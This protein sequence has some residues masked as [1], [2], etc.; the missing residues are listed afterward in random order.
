MPLILETKRLIMRPFQDSDL[1]SFAAYRAD[2][3]V[4]EYQGWSMP[5]T[6]KDAAQLITEMKQQQPAIPGQWYQLALEVKA[7]GVMI[8]DCAFYTLTNDPRQAE[9][10]FTLARPYQGQGYAYEAVA[11]LLDYLFGELKLHRVRAN[12]D[13]ENQH[14]SKLLERLG[15][16]REAHFVENLWFKGR[17]SSEYW[18]GML[19]REWDR[20]ELL[21]GG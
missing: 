12:C 10:G 1:Q 7:S 11:R 3:L 6:Q 21:R 5:Y 17:W 13:V 14:S 18:Y 16:R 19:Q 4:A 15:M 2:P 9:I 20:S 8:G